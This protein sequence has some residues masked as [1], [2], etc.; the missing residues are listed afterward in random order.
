M[1][2]HER[3]TEQ[4]LQVLL[5]KKQPIT[6][7]THD[8]DPGPESNLQSKIKDHCKQRGWPCL[9]FPSTPDVKKFLP[10]GW[11]DETIIM[12][13]NYTLFIEDKSRKGRVSD[14]QKLMRNMFNCLGHYIYEVRSFQS[15]LNVVEGILRKE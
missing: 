10:A 2:P 7:N 6:T 15:F 4:D 9:S 12:P 5:A 14:N 8:P 13:N 11:P 1:T 3:M